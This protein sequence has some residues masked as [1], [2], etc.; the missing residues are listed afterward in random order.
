[1]LPFLALICPVQKCKRIVNAIVLFPALEELTPHFFLHGVPYL[2]LD[3]K[4]SGREQETGQEDTLPA[5]VIYLAM[6]IL[7]F[8]QSPDLSVQHAVK[9]SAQDNKKPEMPMHGKKPVPA[10][11]AFNRPVPRIE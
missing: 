10:L 8:N 7:I 1:M 2:Y 11:P 4:V 5:H 3:K 9:L 6:D